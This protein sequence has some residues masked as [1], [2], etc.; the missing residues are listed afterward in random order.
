MNGNR[1]NGSWRGRLRTL[2][3]YT[4][5]AWAAWLLVVNAL[6]YLP[7]T[8]GLVSSI[9]PEKFRVRWDRAWSVI[10]FHVAARGV[11]ANGNAKRQMWQL[12]AATVS[13]FINP[14]P[15]LWKTVDLYAVEGTEVDF[16]QRPRPR[17]DR[18]YSSSEAFF[19][20]IA[21]RP[22]MPADTSPYR[23]NRPW[24]VVV[25]AVEISGR[26]TYWVYQLQG[27]ARGR[28]SGDLEYRT[29][30]GPLRLDVR[31]FDLEFESNRLNGDRV[32]F[33]SARARGQALLASASTPIGRWRASR[34]LG[35]ALEAA[36]L[37]SEALDAHRTALATGIETRRLPELRQRIA[38]LS[39]A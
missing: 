25:N 16:R 23:T 31:E 14:V 4:L 19:P 7:P 9:R 1:R 30:G 2:A 10:P 8:Q 27:A 20:D 22:V 35:E 13:G 34:A 6:L 38:E 29:R 36:G 37:R 17:P 21:G 24:R 5:L 11:F 3:R 15:L 33:E 32:V 39:P 26:S 12:E 18:D 28:L